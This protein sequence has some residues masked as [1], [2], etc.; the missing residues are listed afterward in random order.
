MLVRRLAELVQVVCDIPLAGC[1][2]VLE[3]ALFGIHLEGAVSETTPFT[4]QYKLTFLKLSAL[5][6]YLKSSP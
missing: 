1:E 5:K 6:T 2:Q 3:V 4:N